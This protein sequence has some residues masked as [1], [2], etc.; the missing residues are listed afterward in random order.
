[1]GLRLGQRLEGPGHLAEPDLWVL[2]SRW[3]D[4]GAYRRSYGGYDA[5]LLLW[6]LYNLAID[7]PTAYDDPEDVGENVPRVR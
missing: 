2:M 3:A 7:E 1:M 4:V 6:P 5:K